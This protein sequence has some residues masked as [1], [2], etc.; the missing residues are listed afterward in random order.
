[1]ALYDRGFS[2]WRH[3]AYISRDQPSLVLFGFWQDWGTYISLF[4]QKRITDLVPDLI[5]NL[6]HLR[7]KA[8]LIQ[9]LLDWV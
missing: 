6:R 3:Q 5:Q 2:P 9:E 1:M 7:H 4:S 8:R